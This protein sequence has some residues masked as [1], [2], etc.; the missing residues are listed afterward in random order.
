[1]RADFQRVLHNAI[2]SDW[3]KQ[4]CN[5]IE[6]FEE[7]STAFI[8][9]SRYTPVL[10]AAGRPTQ[11]WISLPILFMLWP[12]NTLPSLKIVPLPYANT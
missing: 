1:M 3:A 12:T 4:E 7:K 6:L 9:R 8:A 5:N 10:P 2:P 11:G